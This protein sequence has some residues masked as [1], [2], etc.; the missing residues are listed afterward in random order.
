MTEVQSNYCQ[1][2]N[3]FGSGYQALSRQKIVSD[4]EDPV[5]QK[6]KVE[7]TVPFNGI[8]H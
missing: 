1:I 4:N 6:H 5:V 3:Y 2:E 7:I 8:N